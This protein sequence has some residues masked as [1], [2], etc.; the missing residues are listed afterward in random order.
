MTTFST[1]S[2]LILMH[3]RSDGRVTDLPTTI[4]W[5]VSRNWYKEKLFCVDVKINDLH[6]YHFCVYLSPVAFS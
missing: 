6:E 5:A 2:L 4:T 1:S 3:H